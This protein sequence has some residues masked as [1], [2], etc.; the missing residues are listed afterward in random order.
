MAPP[1]DLDLEQRVAKILDAVPQASREAV[2]RYSGDYQVAAP[3]IW[4]NLPIGVFATW[5][6]ALHGLAA[7]LHTPAH[8]RSVVGDQ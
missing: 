6:E 7:Q 1:E 4:Y 2:R 8:H 3:F 5:K